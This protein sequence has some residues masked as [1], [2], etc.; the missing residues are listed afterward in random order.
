VLVDNPPQHPD[1]DFGLDGERVIETGQPRLTF[2]G[3]GVYRPAILDD[4][5]AIIGATPGVEATPPRL[6]LAPLLYAAIRGQAVTGVHHRGLWTDV[7]TPARLRQLD[8]ALGE[9]T[10][11]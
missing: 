2:S 1:G 9:P 6:K 5:R 10:G 8:Q 7:G 4:W 11:H 3:I